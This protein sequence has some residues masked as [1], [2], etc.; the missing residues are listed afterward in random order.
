[1]TLCVQ[2]PRL[3]LEQRIYLPCSPISW[4]I[5]TMPLPGP[6]HVSALLMDTGDAFDEI[7]C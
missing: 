4:G 1:M 6:H 3:E 2:P 5:P 7:Q